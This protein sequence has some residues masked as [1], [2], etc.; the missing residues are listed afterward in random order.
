MPSASVQQLSEMAGTVT[1]Q[2]RTAIAYSWAR[3]RD[4]DD[5]SEQMEQPGAHPD[6]AGEKDTTLAAATRIPERD[7][8]F[9]DARD[10]L[11]LG[12]SAWRS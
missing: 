1:E 9:V 12:A 3:G 10:T 2:A 5:A 6:V 8:A 4:V 7:A 11:R